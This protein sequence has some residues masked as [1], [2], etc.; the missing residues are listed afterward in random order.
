MRVEELIRAEMPD[1]GT[2]PDVPPQDPEEILPQGPQEE[3]LPVDDP[4]GEEVG[5]EAPGA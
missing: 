5:A 3:G 4:D 2:P 1:P